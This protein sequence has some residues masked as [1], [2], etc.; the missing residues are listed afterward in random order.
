MCLGEFVSSVEHKQI[1]LTQTIA[2]CQS[3][4]A[5]QWDS[6]LESQKNIHRQNLI[7]SCGSRR[8]IEVLR[9]ETISKKLA[10]KRSVACIRHSLFVQQITSVHRSTMSEPLTRHALAVVNALRTVGHCG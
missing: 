3:Y 5:S 1:F 9:H 2:V 8:Y 10:W 7:K 4:N 6:W